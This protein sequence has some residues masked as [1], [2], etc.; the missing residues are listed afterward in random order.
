MNDI[1]VAHVIENQN[2]P[3][4]LSEVIV[5]GELMNNI[6]INGGLIMID[7]DNERN[8]RPKINLHIYILFISIMVLI[9]MGCIFLSK[10]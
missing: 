8:E 5:P 7:R 10:H 2:G 6:R 9:C 1:P 4:R 3:Y